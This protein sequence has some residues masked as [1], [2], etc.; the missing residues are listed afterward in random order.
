MTLVALL[1]ACAPVGDRDLG[2]VPDPEPA[3]PDP[4]NGGGNEG[5]AFEA[6]TA[7]ATDAELPPAN[8]L[9]LDWCVRVTPEEPYGGPDEDT[10]PTDTA[11]IPVDE[12]TPPPCGFVN[13]V[14]AVDLAGDPGAP[15]ILYC[16]SD[17]DGGLRVARYD[18]AEEGVWTDVVAPGDCLPDPR[19]GS[20]RPAEGGYLASWTVLE[21][22]TA[23]ITGV[24][25][26]RLAP[27]GAPLGAM[28]TV[29][30]GTQAMR[31]DIGTAEGAPLLTVDLD[32]VLR[33]VQVDADGTPLGA[34]EELAEGVR[35]MAQAAGAAGTH[36]VWC[37]QELSLHLGFLDDAGLETVGT[38]G[39]CG[40]FARPSV[41][42]DGVAVWVAWDDDDAGHLVRVD[43][44]GGLLGAYELGTDALRPQVAANGSHVYLAHTLGEVIRWDADG[45]EVGRWSVRPVALAPGVPMDLRLRVDATHL[46]V[47]LMGMD[48][49]PIAGGHINSFNYVEVSVAPLPPSE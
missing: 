48:Y 37:D 11:T 38:L 20:L 44:A 25:L 36:V 35:D 9:P 39:V 24:N 12:R 14:G 27:S 17:L 31:V 30:T 19:G 15:Q 3:I 2:V 28:G 46:A 21:P 10:A 6:G 4:D 18:P 13:L 7:C 40:D 32:G 49:Y 1:L 45:R 26:A 16:D 41:A 23:D 33:A 42:F 47:A 8:T 22:S 43:E 29:E 34:P 5:M